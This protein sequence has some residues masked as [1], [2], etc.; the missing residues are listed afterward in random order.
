MPDKLT[1][2]N[3][4][5]HDKVLKGISG[6]KTKTATEMATVGCKGKESEEKH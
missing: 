5:A 1:E 2:S 4:A 6:L 3:L